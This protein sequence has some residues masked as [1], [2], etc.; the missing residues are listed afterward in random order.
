[1]TRA[2]YIADYVKAKSAAWCKTNAPNPPHPRIPPPAP[3]KQ[4]LATWAEMAAAQPD[5][6]KQ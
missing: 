2:E 3:S 4:H 1:M 5:C 6:P